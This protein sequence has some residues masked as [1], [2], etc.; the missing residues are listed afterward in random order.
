[1]TSCVSSPEFWHFVECRAREFGH[2]VGVEFGE[3]FT[4]ERPIGVRDL[5]G[6]F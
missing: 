5:A 1:M 3:G 2:A 6:W 4:V